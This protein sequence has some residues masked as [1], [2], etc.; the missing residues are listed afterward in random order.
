MSVRTILKEKGSQVFTVAPFV[1]AEQA[2][3]MMRERSIAALVVIDG[4]KIL[5][6]LTQRELAVGLARFGAGLAKTKVREIM[7]RAFVTV[8]PNETSREVMA[9]MTINRATHIPVMD[10]ERLVGLIS[11]GDVLKDRMGDLELEANVLR[12]AYIAAH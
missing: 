10:G 9:L 1:T 4:E 12:D 3:S 5:G 6:L 8:P 7:R 2:A 11:I